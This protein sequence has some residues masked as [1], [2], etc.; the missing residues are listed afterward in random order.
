MP[1]GS[2]AEASGATRFLFALSSITLVLALLLGG[3]RGS[4]GEQMLAL[5]GLALIL[6]AAVRVGASDVRPDRARWYW[7]L[8]AGLV[9]LPLLQ[10]VPLPHAVWTL[11]PGRDTLAAGM[12][13]A[14]VPPSSGAWTLAP[15]ATEQILWSALVPAGVFMSAAT[16][17]ESQRRMMIGIALAFAGTSAMFGLWQLMEET[18]RQFGL[19]VGYAVD[20]RLDPWIGIV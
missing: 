10:L 18:A 6:S 14:G 3:G 7:L 11:L 4:V 19:Q 8:P 9:V 12:E 17:H 2:H 20:D 5:P 13:T 15:F 1:N 16:L